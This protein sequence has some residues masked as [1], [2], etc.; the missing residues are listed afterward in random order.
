MEFS[1]IP[2][3][4]DEVLDG[5]SLKDDGIYVDGT[6]GGAGHSFEILNR[7]KNA[8]VIAFDKDED[9]LSVSKERLKKFENRVT[10]LHD[11][12]KNAPD[13]LKAMG[14]TK[15][16]GVLLDLG[17]SSYQ[18]DNGERGF[19]INKD[20]RLDMRMDQKSDQDAYFVVNNYSEEEL[21]KI[22]KLYG[23]EQ[24]A[25]KIALNIV[26]YR[27]K[28]PIETTL[29]LVNIIDKSVP[30]YKNKSSVDNQR[31]IFQAIRIEVNKELEGLEETII[32]FCRML[33][34]GGRMAVLTF[35]SLEDRAT[36]QAFHNLSVDCI[37]PPK[38]PICICG[39]KAEVRLINKKP[40]IASERELKLNSRSSCAKLR[41]VEKL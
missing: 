19:S 34:H 11:D 33:K 41:V 27:N 1:H 21:T 17:V 39:H 37:C 4:K 9:A 36:K 12:F 7:T 3:M 23:E 15:V 32:K 6:V 24:F 35:H 30:H 40:I 8:K 2:V 13:L 28:K 31:R 25:R 22:F 26:I 29:E 38:T 5:L 18:L 20:A 14:I 10:F 16:D